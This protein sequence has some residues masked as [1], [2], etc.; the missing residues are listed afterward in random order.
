MKGIYIGYSEPENQNLRTELFHVILKAGLQVFPS[1]LRYENVFYNLINEEIEAASCA[2]LCLGN[3][4]GK[5]IGKQN[6]SI[7][8]YQYQLCRKKC[9]ANPEFKLIIWH[10]AYFDTMDYDTKQLDLLWEIRN[11]IIGNISFTNINSPI[12]LVADIRMSL[13]EAKT[14]KFDIK[15]TDIFLA[16]NELDESEAN[17]ISD[18]L[19]DIIPIEKLNIIQDSDIDYSELCAQQIGRSKMAVVYFKESADWALPFTQQIWKKIGGASSHTP[20]LLIGDNN[21][22]ANRDKKFKAQKV[23]SLIV[24]G[25]LIPLEI[26]VQFDKV[27]DAINERL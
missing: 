2:V 8:H 25:E 20:L 12:Q 4:Y 22:E 6:V 11:E 16:F 1:N 10:P 18:M 3:N 15:N 23:I 5:N 13:Q 21:Y 19:S 7:V 27:I 17:E 26:K 9:L 24:A 14:I